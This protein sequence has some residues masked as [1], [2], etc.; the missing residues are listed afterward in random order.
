MKP[1]IEQVIY[2]QERLTVHSDANWFSPSFTAPI[3]E[4]CVP[5]EGVKSFTVVDGNTHT[6]YG[7]YVVLS[8]DEPGYEGGVGRVVGEGLVTTGAAIAIGPYGL[9]K[10]GDKDSNNTTN[11]NDTDSSGGNAS[12]LGVGGQGGSATS[13]SQGGAGGNGYGYGGKGGSGGKVYNKGY[14]R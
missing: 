14:R 13:A 11:N 3:R 8:L 5:K 1:Q 7:E 6:C 9:A 4:R 10:M 2:G 12:S